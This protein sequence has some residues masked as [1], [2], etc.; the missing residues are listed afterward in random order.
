MKVCILLILGAMLTGCA[1]CE[2]TRPIT[3]GGAGGGGGAGGAIQVVDACDVACERAA[4]LKCPVAETVDGV[5]CAD[6]CRQV[7]VLRGS[8]PCAAKASDCAAFDA[9]S[10]TPDGG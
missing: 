4:A 6:L 2:P 8:A 7:P 9:C 3:P 5:T 10:S 1:S